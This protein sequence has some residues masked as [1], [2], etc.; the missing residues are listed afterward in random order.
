[1]SVKGLLPPTSDYPPFIDD[2][3]SGPTEIITSYG[4]RV[5][6]ANV[7]TGEDIWNGTASVVPIPPLVGQQMSVVS[8]SAQDGVAGTGILT[9]EIHYIDAN[10]NE[11]TEDITMNGVAAV[12]TIATNIRFI[13]DMHAVT[14]GTTKAAVGTI[15]IFP[16][17]T[18][19][20]VYT[21]ISVGQ[22]RHLNTSRMVPFGKTCLI[23]WFKVSPATAGNG[24]IR[25]RSTSHHG[26]PLTVTPPITLFITEDN[27]S[28]FQ[29][30]SYT[31]YPTPI[32]IPALAIIKCTAFNVS[33]TPNVQCSWGGRFV[34]APV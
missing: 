18:P 24:D 10:G 19:A 26:N 30:A 28:I 6:V 3:A 11:Q 5:N 27:S 9:L 4:F 1:M 17:G 32:P 31:S 13:N 34:T 21:Q 7:S 16:V 25:I 23:D 22:T 2:I 14:A 8:T 12:N 15:T 29:S 33:G 20:T